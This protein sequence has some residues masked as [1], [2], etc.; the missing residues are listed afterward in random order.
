MVSGKRICLTLELVPCCSD[1]KVQ[2]PADSVFITQRAQV[3]GQKVSK[4]L[5]LPKINSAMG[6]ESVTQSSLSTQLIEANKE[7]VAVQQQLDQ[8]KIDHNEHMARCKQREEVLAMKQAKL[9]SEAENYERIIGVETNIKR[10]RAE[11]RGVSL[12]SSRADC[13]VRA[14]TNLLLS[15]NNIPLR[16]PFWICQ[17][18]RR[19]P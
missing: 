7:M 12:K 6:V 19:K 18:R 8:K 16:L 13:H 2:Q 5:K 15:A 3:T 10:E 9:R 1:G 11:K 14:L 17:R 4:S